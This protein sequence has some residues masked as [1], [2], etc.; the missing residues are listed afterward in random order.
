MNNNVKRITA[1]ATA[2]LLCLAPAAAYAENTAGNIPSAKPDSAVHAEKEHHHSHA[3]N[4]DKGFKAARGHFIINETSKLLEMDRTEI[5]RSLR[6]GKTLYTLAQEKKGWTEEQYIQKLSDAASLKLDASIKEGQLTRE[7]ADKLK[8]SLPALMKLSI[9]RTAHV[10]E[11][12]SSAL[13]SR[14]P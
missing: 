10:Q 14:T 4:M 5:I 13:P 12:K 1:F 8:A 3:P 11:P 9:S 6:A 2:F 7:E